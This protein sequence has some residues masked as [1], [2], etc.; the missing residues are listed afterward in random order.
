LVARETRLVVQANPQRRSR[1]NV[2]R[3]ISSILLGGPV[4]LLQ[5]V[6]ILVQPISIAA[7]PEQSLDVFRRRS[8]SR[9]GVVHHTKGD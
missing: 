5:L 4:L 8:P 3:S 1:I 9:D 7:L 2:C 6:S